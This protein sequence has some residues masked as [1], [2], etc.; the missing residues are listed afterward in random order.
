MTGTHLLA[1]P[2]AEIA[3]TDTGPPPGHPDAPT[4]VLGHGLLFGGWMFAPQVDALRDRFRCVTLDWRGQG[5]SP[6]PERGYGMDVLTADAVAL[7]DHLGVGPV[8]WVGLSMGGFVGLRLAARRPDLVRSLTLLN[9]SAERERARFWGEDLGLALTA[10]VLGV[11]PLL[12]IVERVM[13]GAAFR[14]SSRFPEV[15]RAWAD[16]L[17]R[18]DRR[19]LGAAVTGVVVRRGV[20]AELAAITAPTLVVS[21]GEDR[22]TAPARGRRIAA[23]VPGARF[24][25]LPGCG[26]S[27][28][29]EQPDAVT[30]LLREHLRAS[31]PAD[32]TEVTPP[33]APRGAGPDRR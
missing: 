20:T 2:G 27:S 24:V 14:R 17:D 21:G 18:A 22:P 5:A 6:R 19:A 9:T 30:A 26:H 4:V 16:R 13:F 28:T 3:W 25:V 8:H 32:G 31:G 33:S 29:L 10:R 1:R 23:G 15:R 12:P 11:R 7:V